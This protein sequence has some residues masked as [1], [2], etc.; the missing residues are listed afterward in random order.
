MPQTILGVDVGSY[1]VKVAELKRSFKSFEFVRF[2]ERRIQ[3]NELLSKE[4]SVNAALQGILDEANTT[5]DSVIVGYPQQRISSRVIELPFGGLKKIDQSIEFEVEG[6]LPVELEKVL[7]D[8][9][10]LKTSKESSEVLVMYTLK[11]DF[12]KWLETFTRLNMDP[13]AVVAEG[14]ELFNV[15]M[16]GIVPPEG[17]YVLLDMGHTKTIL[18]LCHGKQLI[19]SRAI[20]FG[21]QNLTQAIQKKLNIPEAEAEKLKIEVAQ[22][23]EGEGNLDPLTRDVMNAT[24]ESLEDLLVRIRQAMFAYQD[25]EGV[26]FSGIYLTGGG[27]R[28]PGL[29]R[30]FS[31]QLRQNVTHI[32]CTDFHFSHLKQA[33]AHRAVMTQALGLSLRGVAQA[34]MPEINFRQGDFAFK[35]DVQKL[36]GGIRHAAVAMGLIITIGVVYFGMKYFMLS[37]RLQRVNTEI[38]E[39]IKKSLPNVPENILADPVQAS[40][41][42]K[43]KQNETQD[44]LAKLQS[45]L[46]VIALTVL[47]ELSTKVPPRNEVKLDIENLSV[48]KDR[49]RLDGRADSFVT[50]DK[51]KAALESSSMF[52]KV[53]TGDVRKGV[54]DE[55]KFNVSMEL[56]W[57]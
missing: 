19:F 45:E 10:V 26:G 27:S 55:V 46:N 30:Y 49:I 8:Y 9:H 47:K 17:V 50:V 41:F 29:D 23:S 52:E 13:R 7:M 6:V 15:M 25:M 42:L 24:K 48:M 3:Y 16:I 44:R 22:V 21:G 57:D 5:W 38:A 34:G 20:P 54:K 14:V 39:L 37:G 1:S 51:V 33:K 36:G 11:E 18:T 28:L 56:K 35:G 53:T 4:E 12:A 31:Q 32:D 40:N 43:S 2:F